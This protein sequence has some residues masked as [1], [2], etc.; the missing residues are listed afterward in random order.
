MSRNLNQNVHSGWLKTPGPKPF[1]S[2]EGVY[3]SISAN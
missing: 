1:K 2:K 3:Y